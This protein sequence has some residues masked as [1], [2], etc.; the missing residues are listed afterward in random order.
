MPETS[1]ELLAAYSPWKAKTKICSV[2]E[3]HAIKSFVE[4]TFTEL[5]LG[6]TRGARRYLTAITAV[7]AFC[8]RE[9]RELSK[10]TVFSTPVIEQWT[11]TLANNQATYR[12]TLRKIARQLG[13]EQDAAASPS[14]PPRPV[15]L[16][17]TDAEVQ[18]LLSFAKSLSNTNR[19][20]S[21]RAL[22]AL[23]LGAGLARSALRDVSAASLHTHDA[24]GTLFVFTQD[25]CVPLRAE[26]ADELSA[27]C[28]LRPTGPLI[29]VS[30][31]DLTNRHVAWVG[32]RAGVPELS[33]DRL[34]STWILWHLRQG[35][36]LQELMDISG[37]KSASALDAYLDQIARPQALCPLTEATP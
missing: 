15:A 37:L 3:W 5:G 4:A 7:S 31:R 24:A 2:A 34:R 11:S 32:Q 29:G 22:L 17:Y 1:S 14:Y 12:S 30:R 9:G 6:P 33:P 23:G 16:G 19:Q 13:I 10:E 18:A 28:E 25:R 27:L 26:F 20:I 35:T 8:F 36:S 21:L